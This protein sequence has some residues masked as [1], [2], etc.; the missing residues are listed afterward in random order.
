[1]EFPTEQNSTK[2][3]TWVQVADIIIRTKFGNDQS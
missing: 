2:N 3:G 1:M